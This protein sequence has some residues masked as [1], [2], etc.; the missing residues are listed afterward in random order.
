M[1]LY[2]TSSKRPLILVVR[3]QR[4][5]PESIVVNDVHV[6]NVQSKTTF[7]KNEV[8]Q[9]NYISK[10]GNSMFYM[11][12]KSSLGKQETKE[13]VFGEVCKICFCFFI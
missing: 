3:I 8:L 9:Q 5:N 10:E 1:S 11:S 12:P 2:T 13:K 7:P 6:L 4:E